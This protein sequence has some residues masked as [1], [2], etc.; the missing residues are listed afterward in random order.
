MMFG[1]NRQFGECTRKKKGGTVD[2]AVYI[3]RYARVLE[4]K[5]IRMFGVY[6]GHLYFDRACPLHVL[7]KYLTC[8]ST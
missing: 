7:W 2:N 1:P 8:F 4:S 3:S 6:A 5:K